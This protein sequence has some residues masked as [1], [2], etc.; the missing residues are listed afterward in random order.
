MAAKDWTKIYEN[1]EYKGRWVALKRD[2]EETVVASGRTAR[3]AFEQ[4]RQLGHPRA[5]LMHVPLKPDVYLVG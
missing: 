5:V 2:D 1:P 4:A 3:Q